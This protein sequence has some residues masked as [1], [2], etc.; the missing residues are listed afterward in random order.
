[1]LQSDDESFSCTSLAL[2]NSSSS[3]VSLFSCCANKSILGGSLILKLENAESTISSCG[4][5]ID[6]FQFA[7][8][9]RCCSINLLVYVSS[10]SGQ[11][12]P[13]MDKTKTVT[14]GHTV[15]DI[16]VY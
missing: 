6:L 7:T 11:I 15:L 2:F 5:I 13:G 1:M 14:Y 12:H 8:S 4:S 16:Y 9:N 3:L 10:H